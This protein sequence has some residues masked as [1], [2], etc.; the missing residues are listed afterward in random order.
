M[1]NN[2]FIIIDF[3]SSKIRFSV[4]DFNLKK[5]FS[6]SKNVKIN[7]EYSDH[8]DTIKYIIR[9]AEKKIEDHIKDVILIL[10]SSD[11]F[12]IDVS[13]NKNVNISS[14]VED[15]HNSMILELNQIISKYYNNY[16]I[17]HVI[18]DQCIIDEKIFEEFPKNIEIKKSIKVDFKVLCLPKKLILTLKEKFKQNNISVKKILCSSYV[19]SSSY[20]KILNLK[21]I[22]FLEI[23]LKRT[24]LYAYINY[25]LRIVK[26]I[27][28][29]SFHIT[30]DISK[31]FNISLEDSEKIKKL[32][33]K[34]ETEFSYDSNSPENL[35]S[36][37][38][39]IGKNIPI[40]IL[41]KVILFRVQEI[42]DL[43]FKELNS[44][45]INYYFNDTE[46]F[47]I[48]EGSLLFSNN[49]FYLDD[50]FN[51]KSINFYGESDE[52][53]C[54]SGLAHYLNNYKKP[55]IIK[56]KNGIFEKFFNY[57]SK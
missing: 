18:N 50:K 34:S 5:K 15:E 25:K 41:K 28:I 22:S 56:K 36:Y 17:T 26:T 52:Q 39:I 11:L 53:I 49:S 31:V 38:D 12:M 23:G 42:I 24:T 43:I 4:F 40:N 10:D 7:N 46:L 3:G 37:K 44:E 8:F 33:N 32:F 55:K 14:K 51:F 57:F 29:G 2:D 48:G 35:I 27:P 47:L 30:Q 13:L 6:E 1:N 45:N 20:L 54:Q 16:Y 21:K 19:K 9:N